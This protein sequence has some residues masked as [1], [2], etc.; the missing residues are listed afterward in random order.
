MIEK[1]FSVHI[2]DACKQKQEQKF[3][4]VFKVIVLVQQMHRADV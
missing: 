4:H 3:N 2:L 1:L